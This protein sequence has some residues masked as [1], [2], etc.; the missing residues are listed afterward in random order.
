M[1]KYFDMMFYFLATFYKLFFKKRSGWELQAIFVI[2][3]TQMALILDICMLINFY[4]YKVEGNISIYAK[5]LFFM[6]SILLLYLN[7][8]KYEKQYLHLDKEWGIYNG[9]KKNLYIFLSF[10]TV[11]FSWCFVFILW[12]LSK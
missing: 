6:V 8:K 11:I 4:S 5:I 12:F 9:F 10:F 2:T 3:V 1:I 7:I